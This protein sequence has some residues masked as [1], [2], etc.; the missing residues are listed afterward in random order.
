MN[1]RYVKGVRGRA[2]YYMPEHFGYQVKVLADWFRR[3]RPDVP[4][5]N[6]V[7]TRAFHPH[8][9]MTGMCLET[10]MYIE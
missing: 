6:I 3:N 7:I 9:F 4:L 8:P 1:Y 10:V 2:P 5:R